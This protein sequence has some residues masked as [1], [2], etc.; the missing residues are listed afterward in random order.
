MQPV[1]NTGMRASRGRVIVT[2]DADLLAWSLELDAPPRARRVPVA[3]SARQVAAL[4]LGRVGG[5]LLWA[6]GVVAFVTWLAS[7][8][9]RARLHEQEASP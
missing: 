3:R 1:V 5:S 7:R 8:A 6:L 2:L 9:L 4:E